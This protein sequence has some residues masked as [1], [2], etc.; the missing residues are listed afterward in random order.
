MVAKRHAGPPV[1]YSPFPRAS[2]FTRACAFDLLP[3]SGVGKLRLGSAGEDGPQPGVPARGVCPSGQCGGGLVWANRR[4]GRRWDWAARHHAGHQAACGAEEK[5]TPPGLCRG[6]LHEGLGWGAVAVLATSHA[7]GHGRYVYLWH[8]PQGP[9]LEAPLVADPS[10]AYFR[11][12]GLGNNYLGSCSPT[13]VSSVGS[14]CRRRDGEWVSLRSQ[15]SWEGPMRVLMSQSPLA[16]KWGLFPPV[17][18]HQGDRLKRWVTSGSALVSWT[19]SALSPPLPTRRRNQTQGTWK[20]TTT[21][22][23]RRCGPV[24]PRGYQPL[25]R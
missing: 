22:S 3:T 14:G 24:W 11:R 9:G 12:E 5:V 18:A 1:L 23:R 2:Y 4:A 15:A 21:S 6:W 17:P 13:E 19:T 16:L 25:R 20:W 8:C 7:A 10:G